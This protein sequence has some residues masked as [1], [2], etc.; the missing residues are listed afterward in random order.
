[1]TLKIDYVFKIDGLYHSVNYYRSETNMDT[2]SM[3]APIVTG[4]ESLT[5]SDLTVEEGKTYFVRFGAVGTGGIEKISDEIT[6]VARIGLWNDYA[7]VI[8][9]INDASDVYH[10]FTGTASISTMSTTLTFSP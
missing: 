3:P 2:A 1:M 8:N 6:I 5:Y 10:A 9:L 7:I 4:I